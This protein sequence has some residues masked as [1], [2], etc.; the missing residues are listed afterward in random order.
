M[1]VNDEE[2]PDLNIFEKSMNHELLLYYWQRRSLGHDV[3]SKI[4]ELEAIIY[5]EIRE[6]KNQDILWQRDIDELQLLFAVAD[7][8]ENKDRVFVTKAV[9]YKLE[10]TKLT[11]SPDQNHARPHFHLHYKT[12]Y[13][14]SYAI[15]T[16]KP[17]AGNMPKKYEQKILQWASRKQKFLLLIWSELKAGKDVRELVLHA[18]EQE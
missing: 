13:A 1:P 15:D 12:E 9:V 8:E 4:E 10:Y 11:M 2:D 14:A 5:P 16:L 17:L 18:D 3:D 6:G 7:E